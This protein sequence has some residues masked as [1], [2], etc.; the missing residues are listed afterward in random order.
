M[1]DL[2]YQPINER[3]RENYELCKSKIRLFVYSYTPQSTEIVKLTTTPDDADLWHNA[4]IAIQLVG[5][6]FEDERLLA[7]SAVIDDVINGQPQ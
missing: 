3:D 6:Q 7:V 2:G 1:K 5:R 4:P